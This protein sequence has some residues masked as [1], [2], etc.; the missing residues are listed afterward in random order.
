M[1][2]RHR[3]PLSFL[4]LLVAPA[5]VAS[6]APDPVLRGFTPTRSQAQRALVEAEQAFL[7]PEG[8]P[9]RPWF[10]HAIFAPGTYTGYASVPLPGVHESIDADDFD[11]ARHQLEALTAAINR[12]TEVLAAVN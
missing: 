1:R 12:A 6:D 10:R 7:L 3:R 8:L 5:L 2:T 9:G 4:I 11:Q